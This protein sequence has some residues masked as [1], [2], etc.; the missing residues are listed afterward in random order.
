MPN[1][2][3][4]QLLARYLSGEC[5]EKEINIIKEWIKLNPENKKLTE[6]MQQVWDSPGIRA[7]QRD[8]DK[9]WAKIVKE[10]SPDIT[11][12]A[13]GAGFSMFAENIMSKIQEFDIG[14]HLEAEESLP[15]LLDNIESPESV[16]GLYIRK[17][18]EIVF[19][20]DRE[21]P[22]FKNLPMPRRDEEII[23][24]TPYTRDNKF[25]KAF[26]VG[27]QTKRGCVMKCDYCS[28]PFL[29]GNRLRI[30]SSK[31]V[32]DE[33]EYLISLGI[34]RFSFVDNIFNVPKSHAEEICNEILR[35]KLD[36]QWSAWFEIK[37]TTK[38]LMDLAHKAGCR[39]A[40]FS[41]DAATDRALTAL[42]KD[43]S[44]ALIRD[45][46][47]FVR[48]FPDI[49]VGYGIF[50][51]LPGVD[52][53]EYLKALVAFVRMALKFYGQGGVGLGWIRIEP[54]TG[55]YKKAVAEGLIDADVDLLPED[56][57]DL[58]KLFYMRPSMKI[59]NSSVLFVLDIIDTAVKPSVKFISKTLLGKGKKR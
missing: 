29:S 39:K 28:Y 10:T 33:I 30:R 16:K 40:G 8:R 56:D 44:E 1:I 57:K 50:L 27:I 22:S 34:S 49:E 21:L 23:D 43:I 58:E 11:L 5:T 54:H 4:N 47:E 7:H 41:P 12:L 35:R 3:N 59:L 37:N 48:T 51:D 9:L 2:P 53:R 46:V 38:E 15:E 31:D 32:V 18:G 52:T 25:P 45:N 26:H 6:T 19:T 14:C 20:G 55:I 42:Q 17:N 13:G 36:V 24:N